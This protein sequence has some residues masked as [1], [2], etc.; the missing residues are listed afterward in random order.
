MADCSW[1]TRCNEYVKHERS[2]SE[3]QQTDMLN[4]DKFGGN[5]IFTAKLHAVPNL[6]YVDLYSHIVL[7][8]LY[9]RILGLSV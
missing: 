7:V 9:V 2:N 4:G 3:V 8:H 1:Y 6:K 5:A